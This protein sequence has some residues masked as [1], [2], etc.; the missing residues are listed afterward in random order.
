[1]MMWVQPLAPTRRVKY[2]A[3]PWP[4]HM[5]AAT[6]PILPLAWEL[7]YAAGADLKRKEKKR[8]ENKTKNRNTTPE[9]PQGKQKKQS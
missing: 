1:M 2:P 7:P 4:W 8:K 3:L 5:L 6:A 9:K